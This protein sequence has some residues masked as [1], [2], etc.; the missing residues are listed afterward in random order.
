MRELPFVVACGLSLA[1]L[2]LPAPWHIKARNSGT[3]IFIFWAFLGNLIYLVN[4]IVWSNNVRN[5]APVWCDIS[6]KLYIG[7]NVALPCA[8]LCIQRRL[9]KITR[10]SNVTLTT[11]QKRRDIYIDMAVG[12]GFPALIMALHYVV[13]GHR[14]DI[15]EDYGCWPSIYP[16]VAAYILILP[17]PW[18]IS[19]I[20]IVYSVLVV[21]AFLQRRSTFNELLKSHS[22]SLS[23]NRYIRLMALASI[24]VLFVFPISLYIYV[25]N[26]I[27]VPP[28]PW[29][30]W[31]YVHS[32]FSRVGYISRF[33]LDLQPETAVLMKLSR[34]C[35]PFSAILFFLFFGMA[36]ETRKQY[37][38]GFEKAL[39]TVGINPAIL[40]SNDKKRASQQ[41]TTSGRNKRPSYVKRDT[42][43][44]MP[45]TS[46]T[47][48]KKRPDT[49]A[50]LDES[51]P[52]EE[53]DY[54]LPTS[55]GTAYS[56]TDRRSRHVP[57]TPST[58]TSNSQLWDTT[59]TIGR[60]AS[61]STARTGK[62]MRS[63]QDDDAT[64]CGV[65]TSLKRSDSMDKPLPGIPFEDFALFRQSQ[66]SNRN[67]QSAAISVHSTS[68]TSRKSRS[69]SLS[70]LM[71]PTLTQEQEHTGQREEDAYEIHDV[72]DQV[73]IPA[74]RT[75]AAPSSDLDLEEQVQIF[76]SSPTSTSF[77]RREDDDE[78]MPNVPN[79]IERAMTPTPSVRFMEPVTPP[80]A[81]PA[82]PEG[83]SAV[84]ASTLAPPRAIATTTMT[85]NESRPLSVVSQDG[86]ETVFFTPLPGRLSLAPADFEMTPSGLRLVY[87]DGEGQRVSMYDHD[88]EDLQTPRPTGH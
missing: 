70:Q 20:S 59:S 4:A 10:V 80:V 43:S 34:W 26:V 29:V 60:H 71:L 3:L 66:I 42:T 37:R 83:P 18:I 53:L 13:Q 44:T 74:A 79:D 61:I 35:M 56:P 46:P 73:Q 36:S 86:A 49:F 76:V 40:P 64:I 21:R 69:C 82:L 84:G 5:P 24:E 77:T 65:P 87:V 31:G 52:F 12:L 54:K 38:R 57:C 45:M 7:F 78:E 6:S 75:S 16:S 23:V 67:R 25:R 14:F 8:S 1:L 48:D 72:F 50:W 51:L 11:T 63:S 33:L 47:T 32:N 15:M 9:Y 85:A 2:I 68:T 55:P 81:I 41:S 62:T 30:S 19:A 39:Q 88:A 58:S 27:K 22:T 17:W 28:R